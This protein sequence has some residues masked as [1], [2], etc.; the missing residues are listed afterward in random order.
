MGFPSENFVFF[1]TFLLATVLD[2]SFAEDGFHLLPTEDEEMMKTNDHEVFQWTNAHEDLMLWGPKSAFKRQTTDSWPWMGMPAGRFPQRIYYEFDKPVII[3]MFGF[4]NR[5][6]PGHKENNPIEFEFVA[7]DNCLIW[8]LLTSVSGVQWANQDEEKTWEVEE[9]KQKKYK[10]YGISVTSISGENYAGIQDL[11]FSAK[12]DYVHVTSEH[13]TAYASSVNN[14]PNYEAK[15]A[16]EYRDN[17]SYWLSRGGARLP[18]RLWFQFNEPKR[19]VKIRFEEI[20]GLRDGDVYEVFA[21]EAVGDCGNVKKQIFLAEAEHRVFQTGKE[22]EN[23]RY[24]PC[25][26]IQTYHPGGSSWVSLRYV[27]FGIVGEL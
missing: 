25:Y 19:V 24:F 5:M 17:S 10:C 22:F 9:L 6:D 7:S 27:M 15:W 26:G 23:L 18:V 13:G 16:F 21:S 8:E 20:Y 11:K 3:N 2:T 4:R 12:V 1:F 14:N